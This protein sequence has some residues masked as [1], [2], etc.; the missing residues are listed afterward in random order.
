MEMSDEEKKPYIG[1]AA[2]DKERADKERAAYDVSPA[3]SNSYLRL[4]TNRKTN[5]RRKVEGTMV[6]MRSEGA[7]PPSSSTCY[8]LR[9]LFSM[10]C[11]F[12]EARLML[13]IKYFLR[14]MSPGFPSMFAR[15]CR[16]QGQPIV[17]GTVSRNR[18]SCPAVILCY[19]SGLY[20]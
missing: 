2:K 16:A 7:E 1:Q 17:D 15:R 8:S 4:H 20:G 6:M 13:N 19:M 5:K 18:T 14:K 10:C 11:L 3:S 12:P 9:C